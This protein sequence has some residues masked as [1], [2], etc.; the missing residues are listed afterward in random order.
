M[1]TDVKLKTTIAVAKFSDSQHSE[2]IDMRLD[3]QIPV[4][5]W[6]QFDVAIGDV[7]QR[8]EGENV[9]FR[10][11]HFMMELPAFDLQF[12]P[13]RGDLEVAKL[14]NDIKAVQFKKKVIVARTVEKEG[15][16][17]V[18]EVYTL[19]L[20][21]KLPRNDRNTD[22]VKLNFNIPIWCRFTKAQ[23]EMDLEN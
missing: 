6:T 3:I 1:F 15:K 21:T 10:T 8:V 19:Q 11:A 17:K 4:G 22:F 7:V 5:N 18:G 2:T 12:A 20:F 23:T 13:K 16:E 14:R 9:G